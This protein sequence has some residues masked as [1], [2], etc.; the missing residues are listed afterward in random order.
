L[1]CSTPSRP[2]DARLMLIGFLVWHIRR[3]GRRRGRA[4]EVAGAGD[5]GMGAGREGSGIVPSS[6]TRSTVAL[7]PGHCHPLHSMQSHAR[8]WS[9][10]HPLREWSPLPSGS[11][12]KQPGRRSVRSEGLQVRPGRGRVPCSESTLTWRPARYALGPATPTGR[13][14]REGEGPGVPDEGA[15]D[16]I[17]S[18]HREPREVGRGQGAARRRMPPARCFSRSQDPASNPHSRCQSAMW[19]GGRRS[20]RSTARPTGM[21]PRHW[22]GIPPH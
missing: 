17:D 5:E 16:D 13:G 7:G 6:T 1:R 10:G 11:P 3:R 21:M 19:G 22:G 20:D 9:R 8:G 15:G 2:L 14:G 4:P 12:T 18:A